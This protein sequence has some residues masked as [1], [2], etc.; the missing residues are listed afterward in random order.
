MSI[1]RVTVTADHLVVEPTGLWNVSDYDRAIVVTL[2]G[3]ERFDRLVPTVDNPN[4]IVDAT[5]GA[6]GAR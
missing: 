6:L 4:D 3:A 2:D 1:N 5:N